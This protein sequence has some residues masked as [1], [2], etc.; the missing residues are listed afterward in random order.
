MSDFLFLV[1]IDP[2][3]GAAELCEGGVYSATPPAGSEYAGNTLARAAFDLDYNRNA[4]GHEYELRS[5]MRGGVT[6][7]GNVRS[8]LEEWQLAAARVAVAPVTRQLGAA[9]YDPRHEA[10]TFAP[11]VATLYVRAADG[12]LTAIDSHPLP[13]NVDRASAE[14]YA[15][16][17]W[18]A[19]LTADYAITV[20][21]AG[22]SVP[23][24]IRL[25][26]SVAAAIDYA[27]SILPAGAIICGAIRDGA[28]RK[29]IFALPGDRARR[30]LT[31]WFD[32]S[33]V[34]GEW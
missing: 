28:L 23:S 24:L 17:Y 33:T 26:P 32:G 30:V 29:V 10:E 4:Y 15:R 16:A 27:R 12:S 20:R 6:I 9:V 21:V 1:A 18:P 11:G 3:T 7:D 13:A 14:S 5:D 34:Y 22:D 19:R 8:S 25:A 2:N 31:A